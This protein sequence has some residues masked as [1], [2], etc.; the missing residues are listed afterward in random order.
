MAQTYIIT[1]PTNNTAPLSHFYVYELV[2]PLTSQPFYV[3]KGTNRRAIN[4]ISQRNNPKIHKSNPHRCNTINHILSHNVPVIINIVACYATEQDAYDHETLLIE[5]YGRRCNNSG[6]LTNITRG[7]EGQTREGN[8]VDQYTMWGEYIKTWANSHE[9]T[10]SN[11]WK[12]FSAINKCCSGRERSY[13]GY[14]WCHAGKRPKMLTKIKPIYQWN[15]DGT[16]ANIHYSVGSAAAAVGCNTTNISRGLDKPRCTPKGFYWT[17]TNT[18][19]S[20]V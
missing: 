9:A 1:N 15:I 12:C 7:G 13:K 20:L 17:T 4:H 10:R 16:L 3:G 6:I 14:L 19:T 8:P 11:G 2:N 18:L 5:Q